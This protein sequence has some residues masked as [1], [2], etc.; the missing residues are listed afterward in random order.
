MHD[1][2]MSRLHD[3]IL[4][5]WGAEI[6]NIRIENL[7]IADRSLAQSIAQQAVEVSKQE[8]EHMMLEKQTAIIETRASNA[9]KEIEI[10]TR[11]E[12]EKIKALAQADADAVI[13]KAKAQKNEKNFKGKE[14]R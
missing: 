4:E 5:E 12:A 1:E 14:R 7:Q 3:H 10:K 6:S 2:S 8:A 13:I 11:A 9:A